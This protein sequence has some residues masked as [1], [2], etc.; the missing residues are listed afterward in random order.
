[1]PVDFLAT[2]TGH[3][4]DDDKLAYLAKASQAL[5]LVTVRD[6]DIQALL[7]SHRPVYDLAV[8]SGG[9]HY[10]LDVCLR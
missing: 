7:Q 8:E 2:R 10:P 5:G 9:Y 4:D 3:R 6:C 1:M